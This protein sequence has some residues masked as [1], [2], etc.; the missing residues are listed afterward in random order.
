MGL[1]LPLLPVPRLLGAREAAAATR[2]AAIAIVATV[3]ETDPVTPPAV[4]AV[5]VVAAA[6]TD[7]IGP[8]GRVS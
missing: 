4:A 6:A 8:R 5:G 7:L 1:R 2:D 3:D